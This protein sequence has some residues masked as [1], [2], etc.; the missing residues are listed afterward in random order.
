M[1]PIELSIAVSSALDRLSADQR[2]TVVL[3][4]YQ[5]FQVRGDRRDPVLSGFHVKSRL[6]T[7]L[8]L[9]KTDSVSVESARRR[10]SCSPFDLRDYFFGELPESRSPASGSA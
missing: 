3:K 1:F 4:V 10:M 2:E 8:E 7:A 6:Y 9:L 5:G